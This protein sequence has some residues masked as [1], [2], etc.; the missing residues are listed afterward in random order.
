[1]NFK[2]TAQSAFGV[3]LLSLIA[4]SA[5]AQV[6]TAT[7]STAG[8]ATIIQPISLAVASSLSFGTVVRPS[9]GSGSVVISNTGGVTTTGGA[10]VLASST[11]SYPTYT[12]G[13]EGGQAYT[14]TFPATMTLTGPSASTITVSLTHSAFAANLSG[15]LGSAGTATFTAGGTLPLTSTSTTGAYTGSYSV[16][17]TYN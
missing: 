7:Q 17:V 13:G 8:S 2:R 11:T 14:V 1:M 9:S 10:V 16:T 4:S 3:V 12:V 15:A 6:N 5:F